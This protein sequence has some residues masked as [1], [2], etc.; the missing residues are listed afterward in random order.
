MGA[1]GRPAGMPS[2][3]HEDAVELRFVTE[4]VEGLQLAGGDG[5]VAGDNLRRGLGRIQG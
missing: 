3:G 5:V 2:C 1:A 4:A